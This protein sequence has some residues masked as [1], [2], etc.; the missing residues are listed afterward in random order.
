MFL[1]FFLVLYSVRERDK[2]LVFKLAKAWSSKKTGSL[3]F[4]V[5][6]QVAES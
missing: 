3:I 6:D 5:C 2:C 1:F 4:V